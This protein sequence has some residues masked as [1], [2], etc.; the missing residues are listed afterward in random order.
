MALTNFNALDWLVTAIVV[1]S[2]AMSIL[3]GFVREVLGLI[4][5][6][7]AVILSL[8]TYKIVGS[9]FSDL[10]RTENLALL[11][12]FTTVFLGT[13]LAGWTVIWAVTR[14]MKFAKL[15]WFDRLLGAA[16]GLI[17]GW[18]LGSAIFLGLTAFD[19]QTERVRSSE[20]AQ[21]LLPGAR[22]FAAIAPGD[23]QARFL[24]GY[25]AIQRWWH[26]QP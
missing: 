25:H 10:V 7:A 6:A 26:E 9:F 16:F 4:T 13:L 12:G 5:L 22:V 17:R 18:A 24:S 14:F 23:M 8:W 20:L 1:F 19:V 21:F 15:Q 2:M 11:L 3:R